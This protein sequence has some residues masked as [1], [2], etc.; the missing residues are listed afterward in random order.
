[1]N[2]IGGKIDH[3]HRG[4]GVAVIQKDNSPYEFVIFT[5]RAL[6]GGDQAFQ[7]IQ[8]GDR[9][10]YSPYPSKIGSAEFAEDVW[11]VTSP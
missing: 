4:M 11:P 3:V 1:M 6:R 8:Q 9:V 10:H 5:P 7:N 2:G